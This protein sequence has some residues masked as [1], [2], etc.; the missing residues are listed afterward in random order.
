MEN[1]VIIINLRV[2]YWTIVILIGSNVNE[3][4]QVNVIEKIFD[5][6]YK[7]SANKFAGFFTS[8][9]HIKNILHKKQNWIRTENNRNE[10]REGWFE[11][12]VS[13]PTCMMSSESVCYSVLKAEYF[14][15]ST[16]IVSSHMHDVI[17]VC[18]LLREYFSLSTYIVDL[19]NI[20]AGAIIWSK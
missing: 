15:L 11:V 1:N 13:H 9:P 16:Y 5:R 4:Y 6:G 19:N 7:I 12:G 18:L 17:R 2:I 20:M 8:S 10:T 3:G 14:S